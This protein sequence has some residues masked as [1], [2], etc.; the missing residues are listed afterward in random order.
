MWPGLHVPTLAK[1][2]GQAEPRRIESQKCLD[3]NCFRGISG[4]FRGLCRY[5]ML[6]H[7]LRSSLPSHFSPQAHFAHCF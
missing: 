5:F 1:A 6:F 7:Q 2:N 4:D 3:F